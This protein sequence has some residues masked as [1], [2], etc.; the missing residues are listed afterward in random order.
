[1]TFTAVNS[2]CTTETV[3]MIQLG[4]R[5]KL[6]RS[7]EDKAFTLAPPPADKIHYNCDPVLDG[8]SLKKIYNRSILAKSI[9]ENT[10]PL[11]HVEKSLINDR[12][13][14]LIDSDVHIKFSERRAFLHRLLLQVEQFY[15]R[16]LESVVHI[17]HSSVDTAKY[18]AEHAPVKAREIVE[19]GKGLAHSAVDVS[20]D[21]AH[22]LSDTATGTGMLAVE[23]IHDAV[24]TGKDQAAAAKV[25]AQGLV[26]SGKVKVSAA[27]LRASSILE[28]GKETANEVVES[29][30]RTASLASAKTSAFA[31][32]VAEKANEVVERGRQIL[33]SHSQEEIA[34]IRRNKAR[35]ATEEASVYAGY[36]ALLRD[37]E[38]N[39]QETLNHVLLSEMRDRSKPF[40][41]SAYALE[42]NQKNQAYPFH[43][44]RQ[45]LSEIR[46]PATLR[47]LNHV[48]IRD[49]SV[50][51]IPTEVKGLLN[52]DR[53][54]LIKELSQS[55][56]KLAHV[57]ETADR[58][59]PALPEG[60]IDL[61]KGNS[62]KALLEEVKAGVELAKASE[63]HDRSA[64]IV[65]A[66][67]SA[68]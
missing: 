29:I 13:F 15:V 3:F 48:S 14:P 50:P 4:R 30:N 44:R 51:A 62:K 1:M 20:V 35:S 57:A 2:S 9:R 33:R 8:T 45:V 39:R 41:P 11:K 43:A 10:T 53:K 17:H 26:D 25:N 19:Q 28:S 31:S 18:F 7:I 32:V 38:Q 23:L 40:I 47:K 68:M 56:V 55:D 52:N 66:G 59:A 12:S 54:K 5:N 46:R 64:P 65:T 61:G 16:V 22:T 42:Q 34:R 63:V 6:M 37:V 27:K 67:I 24:H 58:S 21:V 60:K 49:T 36:A